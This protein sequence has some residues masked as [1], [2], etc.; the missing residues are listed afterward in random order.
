MVMLFK[1]VRKEK[2]L[3]SALNE[4]ANILSKNTSFLVVNH[5]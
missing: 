4:M 2:N 5:L 3:L 1:G